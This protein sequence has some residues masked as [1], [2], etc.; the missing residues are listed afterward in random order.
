MRVGP[1]VGREALVLE[2]LEPVEERRQE[3]RLAEAR[4]P[5]ASR[6]PGC[7]ETPIAARFRIDRRSHCRVALRVR[8]EQQA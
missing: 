5:S 4:V 8:V 6:R 2:R 3:E 7:E 1:G